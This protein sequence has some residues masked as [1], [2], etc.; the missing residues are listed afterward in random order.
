MRNTT[1]WKKQLGAALSAL[2]VGGFMVLTALCML[3]DY[4]GGGGTAWETVLI[5]VCAGILFLVA[6]GIVLALAQRWKEIE[7]GE[8]DEARKY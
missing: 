5:L 7:G 8:E 2:I 1:K 3:F 6:G 4:F